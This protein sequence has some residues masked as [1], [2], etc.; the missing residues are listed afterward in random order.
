MF[1]ALVHISSPNDLEITFSGLIECTRENFRS[2][3]A[4]LIDEEDLDYSDIVFTTNR[5]QLIGDV[6]DGES[7][8]CYHVTI[9]DIET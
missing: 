6:F 3:V 5:A 2:K 8:R 1:L 7:T 9:V 4:F